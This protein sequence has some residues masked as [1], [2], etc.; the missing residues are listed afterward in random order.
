MI[1][2][3]AHM[4]EDSAPDTPARGAMYPTDMHGSTLLTGIMESDSQG[5]LSLRCHAWVDVMLCT[6]TL[7]QRVASAIQLEVHAA[8]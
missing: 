1:D 2:S 3:D 5:I 6:A 8:Q 4:G 7:I